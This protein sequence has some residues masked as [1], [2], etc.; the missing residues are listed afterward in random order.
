MLPI[1]HIR[2]F[3]TGLYRLFKINYFYNTHSDNNHRMIIFTPLM[4]DWYSEIVIRSGGDN[5]EIMNTTNIKQTW[6]I[7]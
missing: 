2:I 1:S 6:S 7:L 3:S 5:E 4:I